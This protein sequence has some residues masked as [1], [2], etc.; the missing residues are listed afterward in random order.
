MALVT[1]A[2]RGLGAIALALGRAGAKVVVNDLS[3]QACDA[4]CERLN[5]AGIPARGAPFDVA[6]GEAVAR[7]ARAGGESDGRPTCWSA[8]PATRTASPWSR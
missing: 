8:T 3:A 7:A 4:A 2:A 1:G 5:A 6:D